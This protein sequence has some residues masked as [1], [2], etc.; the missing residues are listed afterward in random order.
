MFTPVR[1]GFWEMKVFAG[2]CVVG[3]NAVVSSQIE[4]EID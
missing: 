4:V 1:V 2:C 3:M